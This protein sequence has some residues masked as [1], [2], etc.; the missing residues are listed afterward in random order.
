MRY[1]AVVA[2]AAVVGCGGDV[3]KL[4]CSSAGCDFSTEE[5][6]ALSALAD[7]PPPPADKS[8]RYVG[9][10]A[11]EILGQKFFYDVR[12]SGP[13]LQT[14]ALRRPTT[15]ARAPKGQP[16]GVGCIT[17]HDPGHGGVDTSSIPGNVSVG[18]GWADTNAPPSFNVAHFT[19]PFWNGRVDSLWAQGAAA[20]EGAL[21]NGS[22]LQTAWIVATYYRDEYAGV[23]SEHPLPIP[24]SPTRAEVQA[25]IETEGPRAGQCKLNAGACPTDKGCR[26]LADMTGT[27]T[28]CWPTVPLT[29]KPGTKA[30]CQPGDPAEP[31]GDAF[32]CMPAAE[33]T[34]ITRVL[35]N[36]GKALAAYEY[37]LVTGPAAF[38][39]WVQQIK[40]GRREEADAISTEA[41]LGAKLF[42][43]KAACVDCHN[44]PLFSDNNFYNSAVS[45]TGVAV[46][47][48]SDCPMGGVCDCS[49]SPS[50]RNCLP[51]GALD[52]LVKLRGNRF[53]RDSMFSDDPSDKSRQK[54]VDMASEMSLQDPQ[55]VNALKGAWRTPGLRNVALT[56]PYMHNGSIPTLEALV[57]HYDAGGSP[58][59]PGAPNARIKRLFLSAQ[60]KAALI[61][62][63]KS[64]T[65]APPA[66]PLITPPV[67]PQ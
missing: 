16:S 29:G 38:D 60:E 52:G 23:F 31:A 47:A 46:P 37:K 57:D 10:A 27:M 24:A 28:G 21:L 33:Q 14:D 18:A 42:V 1:V 22:R 45:Q 58:Q 2:F 55:Q 40:D 67:L 44:T 59:A 56:P 13:S 53:R 9:N 26:E 39:R 36:V 12:F 65:S 61:A 7:L 15:Q 66:A 30:G 8:N 54:Y 62:F 4:F 64:L 49:V 3:D 11:A 50:G 20:V 32:D 51:W 5:W 48:E 25:L 63:M 6:R 43:G 19:L 34:A 41:R 35:V 17:C